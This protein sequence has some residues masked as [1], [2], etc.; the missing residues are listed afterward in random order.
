MPPSLSYEEPKRKCPRTAKSK[1][2]KVGGGAK[3]FKGEGA[4][5]LDTNLPAPMFMVF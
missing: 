2:V 1:T 4:C 5:R 3:A